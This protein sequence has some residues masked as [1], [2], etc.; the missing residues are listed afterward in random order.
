MET[1]DFLK[2][3]V[4][5]LFSI[6]G[7]DSSVNVVFE[8]EGNVYII[9]VEG[10]DVGNLIGYKGSVINSLQAFL[11]VAC[12]NKY[13]ENINVQVDI[14]GYRQ[15]RAEKLKLMVKE[16][17]IRVNEKG[18]YRFGFLTSYQRRI[19]HTEISENYPNL[20]SYSIGEGR[21]R[22]LVLSKAEI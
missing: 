5:N 6:L 10:G 16:A 9:E 1:K 22:R 2:E 20:V 4:E 7:V 12:K 8:E 3:T 11:F 18:S 14:N 17:A 13:P 21:E 15:K 19:V